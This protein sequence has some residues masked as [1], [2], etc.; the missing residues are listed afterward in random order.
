MKRITLFAL[1]LLTALVLGACGGA[2]VGTGT[3]GT[4]A[5]STISTT[6]TDTIGTIT[7]TDTMTDTDMMTGTMTTD[8]TATTG[9]MSE[10]PTTGVITSTT[11]V[12]GAG[13]ITAPP[14]DTI[15][16]I[17]SN[18]ANIST[19]RGLVEA[20]G[21]ESA[22]SEAGPYTLFAPTDAAFAALPDSTLQSLLTNPELIREILTY[23]VTTGAL[24]QSELSSSSQLTT[25][26]GALLNVSGS[27][28]TIMLNNNATVTGSAIQT[29][30][31]TIYL[32]D[33]VLLPP[34]VTL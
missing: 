19:L 22:L 15:A 6:A 28:N 3:G 1:T 33:T 29:S 27:G 11:V 17:L 20:A 25:L 9:D 2:P 7:D 16:G 13:E 4:T 14:A 10:T 23:H 24:G 32:I 18:Q 34:G 30:N 31:G 26:Q 12:T 21:L 8:T 5:T